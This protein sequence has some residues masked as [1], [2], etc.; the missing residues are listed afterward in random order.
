MEQLPK[1]QEEFQ[2][3]TLTNL[4]IRKLSQGVKIRNLTDQRELKLG[5]AYCFKLTGLNSIPNETELVILID[6]IVSAYGGLCAEELTHAF[7]LGCSKK[8]ECDMNHYQNFS[9]EYLGRILKAYSEHRSKELAKSQSKQLT[10]F[11]EEQID[12][13]QYFELNL[14]MKYDALLKGKYIFTE[15]DERLLYR[16]LNEGLKIQIATVSEK[17]AA[18]EDAEKREI[19]KYR[20]NE[21]ERLN[22]IKA[23]A[24]RICFRNWVNRMAFE[25]VDLRTEINKL[26]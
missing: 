9:A 16:N 17:K 10:N 13:K 15:E 11:T 5:L 22:K 4:S 14:F 21:D 6:F 18:M 25:E 26:I 24:K 1:K 19:K 12:R 7:K 2:T 3:K 20:Q 23:R 8:F